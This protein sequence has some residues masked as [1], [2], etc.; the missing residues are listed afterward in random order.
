M[1]NPADLFYTLVEAPPGPPWVQQRAAA[2]AAELEAPLA[3]E[4]LEIAIVR[5][6]P[7]SAKRTAR[8]AVGYLRATDAAIERQRTAVIE[9]APVRFVFQSRAWRA[10][11]QRRLI[12]TVA[13]V[14]VALTG[15]VGGAVR[16]FS[17]RQETV[18]VLE[19]RALRAR[20]A[21]AAAKQQ[22]TVA[23]DLTL[24]RQTDLL[25]RGGAQVSAD[26]AWLGAHREPGLALRSV[27]WRPGWLEVESDRAPMATAEALA[28]GRW[29][30]VP[31]PQMTAAPS[32]AAR[33]WRPSMRRTGP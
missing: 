10:Q 3:T 2:M 21:L 31:E 5:L 30:V 28:P 17:M 16:W 1:S 23:R 25:G 33:G 26:L 29:R 15:L 22:R 20:R 12:L 14:I 6:A 11:R 9:D 32:G 27:T 7:W 4:A 8:L 24:M 13:F 19:T 18:A